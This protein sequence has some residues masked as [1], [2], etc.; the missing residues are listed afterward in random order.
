MSDAGDVGL[1][2]AFEARVA[3]VIVTVVA[4]PLV[5]ARNL[6]CELVRKVDTREEWHW[7]HACSLQAKC[8]GSNG[9]L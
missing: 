6:Q 5:F 4:V 8:V 9:I 2:A 7:S 3:D 1:P